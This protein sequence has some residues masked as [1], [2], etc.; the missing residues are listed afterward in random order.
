MYNSYYIWVLLCLKSL[1]SNVIETRGSPN[2]R[3]EGIAMKSVFEV[4]WGQTDQPTNIVSYRGATS[5]LKMKKIKIIPPTGF[6]V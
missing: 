2:P 5:R 4:I 3:R 1:N 6:L